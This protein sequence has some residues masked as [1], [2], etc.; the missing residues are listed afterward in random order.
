MKK[1]LHFVLASLLLCSFWAC[2][3]ENE[4]GSEPEEQEFTVQL[5]PKEVA[6]TVGSTANIVATVTGASSYTLKWSSEDE[7][8]VTV[9]KNGR[10]KAVSLGEASVSCV[11]TA[12]D[13]TAKKRCY[14]SVVPDRI[15]LEEKEATLFTKETFQL[16]ASLLSGAEAKPSYKSLNTSI[17]TVSASGLVTAG[18]NSGECKIIASQTNANPDTC[19]IK[20]NKDRIIL[21]DDT[22]YLSPSSTAQLSATLFTERTGT[23]TYKS[24]N[25]SVATVSSTGKV[26][27]GSSEGK[28]MII[29]SNDYSISDTCVIMV[30]NYLVVTPNKVNIGVGER[31]VMTANYKDVT[32]AVGNVAIARMD[33]NTLVGIAPGKTSL[34]AM[35]GSLSTKIEVSIITY[36]TSIVCNLP[37]DL[38]VLA[39]KSELKLSPSAVSVT[40]ADAA[41][42]AQVTAAWSDGGA[43]TVNTDPQ[44]P[45]AC[46]LQLPSISTT[47][48][49]R[50]TITWSV[51]QKG[52]KELTCKATFVYMA[53]QYVSKK[54]GSN[55]ECWGT[56]GTR[57][58]FKDVPCYNTETISYF[59]NHAGFE[60]EHSAVAGGFY[61]Y[62]N[63]LNADKLDY[64][65]KVYYNLPVFDGT[66]VTSTRVASCDVTLH[67][68]FAYWR[69]KILYQE[70]GKSTW[71][72]ACWKDVEGYSLSKEVTVHTSGVV[73]PGGAKV[74]ILLYRYYYVDSSN[75]EAGVWEA[76]EGNTIGSL[77][78]QSVTFTSGNF[79]QTVKLKVVP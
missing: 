21:S 72:I 40:P 78:G 17:A 43:I 3:K 53:P 65:A 75:S 50:G 73:I 32:W 49:R 6:L 1:F 20:V 14:V 68:T 46:T 8:I 58:T 70:S 47:S 54:F 10:I 59:C 19:I 60:M 45:L 38:V 66:K 71:T 41:Q 52:G 37:G 24:T 5:E 4:Q 31:Q 42:F 2:N 29:A 7:D 11:A 56:I 16:K 74:K 15:V 61:V 57:T 44:S 67:N 48:M 30:G 25:T 18:N 9:D 22:L 12:G 13:K 35:S 33:G 77:N 23:F 69:A 36:A 34:Y 55:N 63:T 51:P 79:S 64:T 28:C 27:A 62:Y 39:D 76:V 26:T